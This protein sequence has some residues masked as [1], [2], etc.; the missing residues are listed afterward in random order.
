MRSNYIPPAWASTI[1]LAVQASHRLS[2]DLD[3]RHANTQQR[4]RSGD[5]YRKREKMRETALI[6]SIA[7]HGVK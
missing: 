5:R 4:T 3:G 7:T 6:E 2:S 1:E